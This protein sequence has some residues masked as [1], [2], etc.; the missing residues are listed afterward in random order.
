MQTE[1]FLQKILP[2][3]HFRCS[4]YKN[5]NNMGK[6]WRKYCQDDKHECKFILDLPGR[7]KSYRYVKEEPTDRVLHLRPL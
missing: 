5:A 2:H 7:V 3:G 6:G 1:D 4:T